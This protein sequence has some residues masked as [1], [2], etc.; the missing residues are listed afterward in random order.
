M[1]FLRR[2]RATDE[3][4]KRTTDNKALFDRR[5]SARSS[6]FSYGRM[7]SEP[8]SEP[9]NALVSPRFS[10]KKKFER[11]HRRTRSDPLS[12]K[13]MAGALSGAVHLA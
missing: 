3:A 5:S 6:E 13:S 4:V 10:R 8:L 7:L 1:H 12:F 2:T 11:G 9:L